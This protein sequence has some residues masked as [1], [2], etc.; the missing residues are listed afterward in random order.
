MYKIIIADERQFAKDISK[1][2]KNELDL[3]FLKIENL[4][5]E[6]IKNSKV[7]KLI[8]YPIADFRLRV[9]NYR[10]LFDF[11]IENSEIVI[12]RVLHRSKLY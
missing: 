7:K 6:W 3:I 9:W 2:W 5:I 10:I 11:E 1:I 8:N 12:F 4:K